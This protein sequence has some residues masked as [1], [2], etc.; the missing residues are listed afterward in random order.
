MRQSRLPLLK[1]FPL[2]FSERSL[3]TLVVF[4][5]RQLVE[6]CVIS[7]QDIADVS[8]ID[9]DAQ[10]AQQL[11]SHELAARPNQ[12]RILLAYQPE[13]CKVPGAVL[14]QKP[15]KMDVLLAILKNMRRKVFQP[16]R[17]T[18]TQL[19]AILS[20][21]T[22][23]SGCAPHPVKARCQPD[24]AAHAAMHL[25]SREKY[26]FIG[27]M[28]DIDLE[29]T[30]ER[31]KAFY[32]PRQFLQGFV[33]KAIALGIENASVV[34]LSS[35]A[36]G[37]IEIYPFAKKVIARTATYSL[38]AIARLPLREIDVKID[39]LAAAV[40]F[41]LDEEGV[42]GLDAFLWKLALWASRG[43]LPL[44][45]DLDTPLVLKRWPN[46]TR[47][48]SPPHATRIA[49]LWAR[50]PIVLS[51]SIATLDLPQRY[52]FAFYSACLVH[53]IVAPAKR[54]LDPLLVRPP[55]LD[56][57]RNLLRALTSKLMGN[58]TNK[59]IRAHGQL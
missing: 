54:A 31:D 46:L 8:M 13:Q 20:R 11:L 17:V 58:R 35:P 33:Q 56:E 26:F 27:S 28:P 10:N 30:R 25:H 39:L 12:P 52:V 1:V 3:R 24:L 59:S 32:D 47:L 48:L 7:E 29:N 36:F 37:N 42:E 45:T 15:V 53:G 19:A 50:E 38:S 2:G 55:A 44:G 23:A 22:R 4:F 6:S 18:A 41:P 14:V 16:R 49:G 40:Q 43:R 9:F 5:E 57:K 51:R 21:N 34:R